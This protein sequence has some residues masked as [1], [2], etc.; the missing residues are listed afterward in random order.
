VAVRV[1]G[2]RGWIGVS[3]QASKV[4]SIVARPVAL[5]HLIPGVVAGNDLPERIEG[6]HRPTARPATAVMVLRNPGPGARPATAALALAD[7]QRQRHAEAVL[8]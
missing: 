4:T 1:L 2:M 3:E 6:P 8:V 7:A 5:R